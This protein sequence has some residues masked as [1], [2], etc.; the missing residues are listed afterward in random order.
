MTKSTLIILYLSIGLVHL[1]HCTPALA[2]RIL[3]INTPGNPPLHYPDQT[4]IL[5]LLTREA[6]TRIGAEVTIQHLPPERALI[7]ANAGLDD[8]DSARIGGLEKIYPNLLQVPAIIF[9]TAFVAFTL[10]KDLAINGW[11]DL[12]PYDVAIIR[13]HKISEQ[14]VVGT[15]SLT[16]TD[17]VEMLFTLLKNNRADVV[18]CEQFFGFDMAKKIGLE[19]I[20]ILDPPLATLDFFIYLHKRHRNIVPRLAEAIEKMHE[21]G[22]Y[23]RIYQTGLRKYGQRN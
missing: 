9:D 7:N 23:D 14:N 13:G 4:G 18:V 5:D 22:T 19:D 11:Q 12:K 15:H 21:D 17:N 8:G 2:D 10:R 3:S 1:L 16:K 20:R 6:F